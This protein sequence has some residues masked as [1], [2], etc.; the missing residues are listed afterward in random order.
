MFKV[1]TKL[2]KWGNS[3][4]IVI[5]LR[6]A[7]KERLSEGDTIIA[8]LGRKSNVLRAT[9]GTFRFKKPVQKL[10]DEMDKALYNE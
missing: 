9:F 6:E 3:L 1:K 2:R 4:G 10:I 8:V 5:P 7:R